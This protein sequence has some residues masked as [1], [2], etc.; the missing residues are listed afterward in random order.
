MFQDQTV[1]NFVQTSV[2]FITKIGIPLKIRSVQIVIVGNITSSTPY[3]SPLSYILL[4]LE[5]PDTYIRLID[6]FCAGGKIPK[7]YIDFY[8]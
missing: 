3:T 8:N 4:Y 7:K 6:T 2:S 1:G 5:K